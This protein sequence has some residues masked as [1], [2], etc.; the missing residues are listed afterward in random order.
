MNP[1]L[2][3]DTKER[4][5]I[6]Q[7]KGRTAHLPHNDLVF[8]SIPPGNWKI[9]FCAGFLSDSESK[10]CC[11]QVSWSR[12]KK[13]EKKDKT[14]TQTNH[15]SWKCFSLIQCLPNVNCIQGSA[16][17]TSRSPF[18]YVSSLS[19]LGENH[20][21]SH[22]ADFYHDTIFPKHSPQNK[23]LPRVSVLFSSRG[24]GPSPQNK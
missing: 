8:W 9:V 20:R 16:V 14:S 1:V 23:C 11:D 2:R 22:I 13:K 5:V 12:G 3:R 7:H 24:R 18:W 19:N 17:G 10:P 6:K 15:G 4:G 21:F